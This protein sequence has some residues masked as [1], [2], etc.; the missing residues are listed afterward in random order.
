MAWRYGVVFDKAYTAYRFDLTHERYILVR[1]HVGLLVD[2]LVR[3]ALLLETDLHM[4]NWIAES[5]SPA[6]AE[7]SC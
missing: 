2:L 3:R 5:Q 4:M 6:L 1:A 7:G